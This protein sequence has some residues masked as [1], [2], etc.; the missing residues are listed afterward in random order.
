MKSA[1]RA[2]EPHRI[3][4]IGRISPQR[5][6]ESFVHCK[7]TG[8]PRAYFCKTARLSSGSRPAPTTHNQGS[9]QH[10]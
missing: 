7:S 10:P 1:L 2:A 3:V 6:V 8:V 9:K 5:A 4:V